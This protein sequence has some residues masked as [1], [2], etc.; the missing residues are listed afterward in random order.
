M[1][2]YVFGKLQVAIYHTIYHPR[3][4]QSC[5]PFVDSL[6]AIHILTHEPNNKHDGWVGQLFTCDRNDCESANDSTDFKSL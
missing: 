1:L 5:C 3:T 6:T 2:M 4:V